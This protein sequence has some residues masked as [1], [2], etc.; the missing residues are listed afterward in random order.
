M[1]NMFGANRGRKDTRSR[2]ERSGG[3]GP[4]NSAM[5]DALRRASLTGK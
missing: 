3:S 4:S 5:A 1:I 2:G